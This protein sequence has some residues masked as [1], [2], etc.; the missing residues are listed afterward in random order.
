MRLFFAVNFQNEVKD[1]LTTVQNDLRKQSFCGN[2]TRYENLHLTLVF[3]GDVSESRVDRLVQI[4]GSVKAE[5]FKLR[6]TQ[7]GRFKRDGGD[8]IWI[9]GE[10]CAPLFSLHDALA[11]QLRTAGFPLEAR[12]YTP[13]LTLARGVRLR[14]GF[15]LSG[16]S[17]KS[18]DA[19]VTRASLMKSERISGRLTYTEL[20]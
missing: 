13:H 6:L 14:E 11:T 19:T 2:F 18:I 3:I 15:S 10:K 4:A 17:L 20:A 9:G 7:L 8:L 16:Y 5:P 12:P 1:A